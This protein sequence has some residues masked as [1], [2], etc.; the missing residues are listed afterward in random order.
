MMRVEDL[1]TGGVRTVSPAASAEEAWNTTPRA[2]EIP[3]LLQLRT[4]AL[5][6]IAIIGHH[7]VKA[8]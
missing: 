1:T 2:G 4:P 8:D 3:P 6:R 5:R 7:C